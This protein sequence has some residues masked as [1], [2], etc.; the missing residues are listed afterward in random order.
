MGCFIV[1]RTSC[2][3]L[4][5]SV[6]IKVRFTEPTVI[7]YTIIEGR[8]YDETSLNWAFSEIWST[9]FIKAFN[10]PI[11]SI[12]MEANLMNDSEDIC[13]WVSSQWSVMDCRLVLNFSF[14]HS[15]SMLSLCAVSRSC[16]MTPS[17]LEHI[18]EAT[19]KYSSPFWSQL[20]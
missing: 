1:P 2:E 13:C 16:C 17:L 11:S 8:T 14:Q 12:R 19:Y 7:I 5:V 9:I 4:W 6:Q 15:S 18:T 20:L 10:L 3:I